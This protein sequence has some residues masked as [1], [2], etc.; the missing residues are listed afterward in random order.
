MKKLFFTTSLVIGMIAADLMIPEWEVQD[1]LIGFVKE[2]L[3]KLFEWVN[4]KA[5]A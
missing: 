5:W 2:N 4:I 3:N 1:Q